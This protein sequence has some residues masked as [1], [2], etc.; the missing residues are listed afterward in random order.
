ME[1]IGGALLGVHAGDAL[2]ATVEFSSWSAVRRRYP[3]GLREIA[4]GLL[5]ARDGAGAIPGRWTSVLQFAD[6]FTEAAPVLA[7]A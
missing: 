4:G 2:G 6:E 7:G 5:G 1:R 3:D